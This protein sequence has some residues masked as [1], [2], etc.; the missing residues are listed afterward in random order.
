M[1]M[2]VQVYMYEWM[3]VDVCVVILIGLVMEGFVRK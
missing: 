1:S 3:C 2:Y